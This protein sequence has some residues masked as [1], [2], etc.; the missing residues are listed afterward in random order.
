MGF[1]LVLGGARSGKSAYA[2]R[3][4]EGLAH[5]HSLNVTYVATAQAS[6][7][8]MLTRIDRHRQERPDTWETV[9]VPLLLE[10]WLKTCETSNVLLIDCLSLL[11]NNW[12]FLDGCDEGEIRRRSE[13]LLLAMKERKQPVVIVSSEV[14]QGIVP[15]DS[16][17]RQYRDSLGWINQR[18][19]RDAEKAIWV[20]AG[21]PIDLKSI[22]VT[23][24]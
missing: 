12:M 13:N 1:F 19:A 22:E 16:F 15:M 10:Q 8:E 7:K 20:V 14:G 4:A 17:T 2:E 5:R 24:P 6:D 11:L 9:E 18:M 23:L 21:I 3:L